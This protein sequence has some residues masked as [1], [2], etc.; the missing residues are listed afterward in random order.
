MKEKTSGSLLLETSGTGV[1]SLSRVFIS[2]TR[3]IEA[4]T[5]AEIDAL[6]PA[7]EDAIARGHFA[8]GFFAYECGQSFEPA[9]GQRALRDGDL[10]AWFGIYDRCFC[11]DHHAGSFTGDAPPDLPCSLEA[12]PSPLPVVSLALD[13]PLYS[14]RIAQIH[15]WIRA[16]DVYQI[17]RAHV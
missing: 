12:E 11:F 13:Q 9:A 4:R 15:E 5:P 3:I 14:Q 17:G 1:S 7:I 10:L 8:A 6:F 2:P 16:G